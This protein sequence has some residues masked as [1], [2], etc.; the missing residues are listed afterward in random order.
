M[1]YESFVAL[2]LG[3]K[4]IRNTIAQFFGPQTTPLFYIQNAKWRHEMRR[5]GETNKG[6]IWERKSEFGFLALRG[7]LKTS[8]FSFIHF[9]V[10]PL[11]LIRRTCRYIPLC[12]S[13]FV[14]T[15]SIAKG[16]RKTQENLLGSRNMLNFTTGGGGQLPY[17]A[18]VL[19]RAYVYVYV[20]VS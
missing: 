16:K 15:F 3:H 11:I 17:F 8:F 20:R 13:A 4:N 14:Q 6:E 10:P 19:E 1:T 9:F 12:P 18:F 5:G 2:F 7:C